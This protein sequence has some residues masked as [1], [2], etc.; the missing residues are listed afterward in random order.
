MPVVIVLIA[1][2]IVAGAVVVAMGRGGELAR[3]RPPE[4]AAADFRTWSDVALYRPPS[5]LLG[6]DP[7]AT[8]RALAE[9]AQAMAERDAEIDRLRR[10]LAAAQ[11][12]GESDWQ[13]TSGAADPGRFAE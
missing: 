1:I 10:Q 5:A 7:G 3:E 13:P 4:P 12:T 11:L 2:V 6:Y 9:I 8:E